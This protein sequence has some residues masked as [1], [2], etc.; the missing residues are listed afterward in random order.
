MGGSVHWAVAPYAHK[1][2]A[3]RTPQSHGSSRERAHLEAAPRTTFHFSR[4]CLCKKVLCLNLLGLPLPAYRLSTGERG[5]SL[6][7][8]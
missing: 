8:C 1:E 4:A 5:S 2:P 6:C 3:S 7:Q